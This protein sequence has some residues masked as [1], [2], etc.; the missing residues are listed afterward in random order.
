MGKKNIQ[1]KQLD[2]LTPDHIRDLEG[3]QENC[4]NNLHR[5]MVIKCL[6]FK[7]DIWYVCSDCLDRY[8]K[9]HPEI[10][11]LIVGFKR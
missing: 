11:H 6:G 1:P 10:K 9:D 7:E 4:Y 3:M 2:T 5:P 8:V